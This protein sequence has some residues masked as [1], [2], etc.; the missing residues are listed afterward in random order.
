MNYKKTRGELTAQFTFRLSAETKQYLESQD[1]DL[2]AVCRDALDSVARDLKA[3]QAT[4]TPVRG[5]IRKG[6]K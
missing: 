6:S 1:I 4:V 3:S 5:A 2:A